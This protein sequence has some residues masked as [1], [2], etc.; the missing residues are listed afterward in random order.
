MTLTLFIVFVAL[1]AAFV[2]ARFAIFRIDG[3]VPAG[4]R[5]IEASATASIAIGAALIVARSTDDNWLDV[6]ALVAG[7]ASAALFAWGLRSVRPMQLTAA[8]S[9]DMPADLLRTGAFAFVRN[10]FYLAYIIAHALPVAAS[11]SVWAIP[12]ALWMG[13]I[14]THAAIL[15]ERKFLAS[16]QAD[17]FRRYAAETGRFFPR[18]A[19]L[20][21]SR[22]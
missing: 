5:L 7:V 9:T 1:Q 16:P 2:W 21:G 15:E 22:R 8:F 11:R 4:V 3:P 6:L 10:P 14:Y 17:D 19:R 12:A 18:L 13:A 20:T